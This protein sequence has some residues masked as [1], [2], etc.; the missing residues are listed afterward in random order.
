MSVKTSKEQSTVS[1]YW[2]YQNVP[3]QDQ[4]NS[5]IDFAKSKGNLI[6]KKVYLN[7]DCER[8]AA[9]KT[10]FQNIDFS[11]VNIPCPLKD[12]ADNQ[13]KSDLI[14]D[15]SDYPSDIVIIVSGDGDFRNLVKL[16][17][18]QGKH[19][20]VLAQ[21]GNV[22]Q[23]LKEQAHEFYF[24]DELPKKVKK[25][26]E[27]IKSTKSQIDYQQAVAYLTTA[28]KTALAKG[29]AAAL[30]YINNLMLELFPNYQGVSCIRTVDGKQFKKFAQFVDTVVKDGKVKRKNQSLLLIE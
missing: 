14:D 13:L 16:L 7:L 18:V 10:F 21:K 25:D 11:Y 4:A 22:K 24:I 15:M 12:S 5:I 3:K 19:V 1:I 23:L 9:A 30:G 28:I 29:K 20:I 2:D 27:S 8:Q 26:V 6:I 17:K